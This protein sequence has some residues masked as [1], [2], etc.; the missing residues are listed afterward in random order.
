M[1]LLWLIKVG[2]GT[3]QRYITKWGFQKRH[4]RPEPRGVSRL[5]RYKK[6]HPECFLLVWDVGTKR[7]PTPT[8]L[9]RAGPKRIPLYRTPSPPS[10]LRNGEQLLYNIK[11]VCNEL[12]AHL[13]R[14]DPSHVHLDRRASRSLGRKFSGFFRLLIH[15]PMHEVIDESSPSLQGLLGILPRVSPLVKNFHRVLSDILAVLQRGQNQARKPD[16]FASHGPPIKMMTCLMRVGVE[17]YSSTIKEAWNCYLS[18]LESFV[19]LTNFEAV[20]LRCR[21]LINCDLDL[22]LGALQSKYFTLTK[23]IDLC[24]F[25]QESMSAQEVVGRSTV[26]DVFCL[27]GRH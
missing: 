4:S 7:P 14:P 22:S 16:F 17:A 6:N 20:E 24:A 12:Y 11:I 19:G 1:E 25:G 13:E 18:E 3:F 10:D 23:L 27:F 26:V 9:Q 15:F 8:E 5:K 2:I 21:W